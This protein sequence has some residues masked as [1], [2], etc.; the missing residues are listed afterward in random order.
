MKSGRWVFVIALVVLTGCRS[1]ETI[2]GF[3]PADAVFVLQQMDGVAVP[4]RATL[5]FP[6]P[7][8]VT[9]DGP[10]N[11]FFA[12][13]AV[14]YPWIE[15]GEVAATRRACPELAFESMYFQGLRDMKLI[16]VSGNALILS[17]PAGREMVFQAEN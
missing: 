11:G 15:I 14:P 8:R 10:C 17:T 12:S 9:G 4:A 16:E 6:E 1:D 3:A 7:G 2:S 13:Q 5:S